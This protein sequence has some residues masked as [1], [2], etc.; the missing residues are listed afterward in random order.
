MSVFQY[1]DDIFIFTVLSF[2]IKWI[3]MKLQRGG[4]G[5][6]GGYFV[7]N[8]NSSDNLFSH[9]SKKLSVHKKLSNLPKTVLEQQQ[10]TCSKVIDNCKHNVKPKF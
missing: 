2:S 6:G 1:N 7:Q 4:G 3:I 8:L 5:G 9:L 10:A